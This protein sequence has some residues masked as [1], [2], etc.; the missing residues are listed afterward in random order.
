[1]M[2]PPAPIVSPMPPGSSSAGGRD[3]DSFYVGDCQQAQASTHAVQ[4]T[5]GQISRLTGSLGSAEDVRACWELVD[6]AVRQASDTQAILKRILEHQRQ[7]QNPSERSTR[8][9][10]Y[11]KLSDN[12]A[13]TARVLEDAVQRFSAAEKKCA[14]SL[15]P[16]GA[17]VAPGDVAGGEEQQ[18]MADKAEQHV[19]CLQKIYSDLAATQTEQQED[20]EDTL[21][22]HMLSGAV[23]DLERGGGEDIAS[24]RYNRDS[25]AKNKIFKIAIVVGAV[26]VIGWLAS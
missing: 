6:D 4:T 20:T 11:H 17:P 12:L 18:D 9:M 3:A 21:E 8:K 5:T 26:S 25:Q 13:I 23:D 7:A 24:S 2:M 16:P 10:T 14:A 19:R 22:R 1:M 15:D